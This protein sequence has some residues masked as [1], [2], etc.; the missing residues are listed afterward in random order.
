[1]TAPLLK[2]A[3]VAARLGMSVSW[4]KAAA[5]RG[6]LPHIRMPGPSGSTA[7]LRFSEAELEDWIKARSLPASLGATLTVSIPTTGQEHREQ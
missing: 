5:A 7:A 6:D 2:P 4:V 1:V 3:E